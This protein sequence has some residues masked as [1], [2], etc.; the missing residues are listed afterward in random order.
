MLSQHLPPLFAQ[1]PAPPAVPVPEVTPGSVILDE[2]CRAGDATEPN[3]ICTVV[4]DATGVGW[5]GQALGTL[6]PAL[7]QIALI[8][9][10]AWLANR[11]VRTAIRRFTL[12]LRSDGMSKL[13][14]LRSRG[15]LATTGPINLARS[16]MRTETIGSVLR[17]VTSGGILFVAVALALGVVGIDLGPLVAG[18]GI[19]G[20]ALG[21]G[22]Q[23]LVKDLISGIFILYE[24]QYGIGDIVEV[25]EPSAP[26]ATGTIEGISL[27]TTR[28]R[29]IEGTVWYVPNGEIRRVGNKSQLWARSLIDVGVAYGT[30]TDHAIEVIKRTAD[31]LWHD[32]DWADQV[33]EEPEVWGI[34][35]FGPSEV[36]IRLVVKV[37]PARQWAVNRELRARLLTAFERDGIE[38][39]F[40]QQ[41]VW[42]HQVRDTA[43]ALPDP[44]PDRPPAR[45]LERDA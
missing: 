25:G 28:L 39:P 26:I 22:S 4:T 7:A 13:S 11:L 27:R 33:L 45:E 30:D 21:F 6:I 40:P 9:G 43:S 38:I 23:S 12:R 42:M 10:L 3:A 37:E 41:T 2:A 1:T 32:Q 31:E 14:G 44:P 36:V 35:A 18:A 8:V 16:N 20:V 15:P 19:I 17:S 34:E 5:L 24:D 29:D